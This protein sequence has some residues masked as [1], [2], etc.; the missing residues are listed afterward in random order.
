MVI[1][2][3]SEEN[4]IYLKQASRILADTLSLLSSFIVPGKTGFEIDKLAEDYIRSM[5]GIPS[6]KNYRGYPANICLSIDSQ[7]VHVPPTSKP[8]LPGQIVKVDLTVEF[9]GFNADSA[10]TILIPPIKSEVQRLATVGIE[11]LKNGILQ[12]KEGNHVSDITQV[13]FNT[14]NGT[15]FSL[16]KEFVGHGIGKSI[17]EG[18]QVPCIPQVSPSPLLV[19]NMVICIEPIVIGSLDN[20]IYYKEGEW[21]TWSLVG[22]NIV[23]NE[24]TILITPQGPEILT[25]RKS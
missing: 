8:I 5:G 7:A 22:A 2:L 19:S 6:C 11:A 16:C 13:I 18:P 14:V 12:A 24:E 20:S 17:H 1:Y 4:L 23:H 9:Q 10:V 21:A 3:K 25:L 15:G